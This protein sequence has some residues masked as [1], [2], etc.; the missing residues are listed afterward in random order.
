MNIVFVSGG[1]DPA[2]IGHLDYLKSA[3]KLGDVYVLLNSDEWLKRKKGYALLDWDTRA[4]VL[5]EMKSVK[6]VYEVGDHD[7][8]VC[9]GLREYYPTLSRVAKAKGGSV[10]FAKGGDRTHTN[11]PEQQVCKELGIVCT[12]GVGGE[13]VASSSDIVAAVRKPIST[14][15]IHE[16]A[17]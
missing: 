15:L 6:G 14:P 1:F 17:R 4:A 8:T 9:D 10:I 7:N 5:R 2:H 13:K 3:A 12:F 16:D 11:T